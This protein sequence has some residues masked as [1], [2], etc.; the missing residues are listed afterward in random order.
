MCGQG[1]MMGPGVGFEMANLIEK[2]TTEMSEEVF[3][4]LSPARNFHAGKME[5]LK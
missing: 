2:G 1:F 4:T 3:N 5:A